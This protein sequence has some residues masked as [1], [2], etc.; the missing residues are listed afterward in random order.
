M[1]S[2]S[3]D[4]GNTV[5]RV[6]AMGGL[7][8]CGCDSKNWIQTIQDRIGQSMPDMSAND[9]FAAI[10]GQV[11]KTL[12]V[13]GKEA[14]EALVAAATSTDPITPD[15]VSTESGA[16]DIATVGKKAQTDTRFYYAQMKAMQATVG[17]LKSQVGSLPRGSDMR[18]Q[19]ETK[20]GELEKL[21]FI[22]KAKA[23]RSAVVAGALLA[24]L[25]FRDRAIKTRDPKK[26]EVLMAQSRASVAVS[27][28]LAKT[29]IMAQV[30]PGA[31]A[32]T[33]IAQPQL[34]GF[35]LPAVVKRPSKFFRKPFVQRPPS[36]GTPSFPNGDVVARRANIQGLGVW[37]FLD[38]TIIGKLT[39]GDVNGAV[40]DT[41][42]LVSNT[43]ANLPPPTPGQAGPSTEVAAEIAAGTNSAAPSGANPFSKLPGWAIPVGLGVIGLGVA[44]FFI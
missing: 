25:R 15:M 27:E 33:V 2:L 12:G 13:S 11:A 24:A 30:A 1:K 8:D 41:V 3:V 20:V 31:T 43:V 6:P 23:Q 10:K 35:D 9:R 36:P 21:M 19:L 16:K 4:A 34:N 7:G 22:E 42:N 14:E 39:N 5:A 38:H 29:D 18:A 28:A 37:P 40:A 26:A 44:L 17:K 32:P